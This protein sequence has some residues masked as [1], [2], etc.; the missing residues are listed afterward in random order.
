MSPAH[1]Q[2]Q[3]FAWFDLHGRR[4]L[5]WQQDINPYR[6]W[7]SEIMLQQ[8][9]VASVIGYFQR[10]MDRFPTV[11]HLAD[12]ELDDVL[13]HWAGLGYYA[14]A[15]NLHKTARLVAANGGEFPQT[16][17][18]LSALPGIG[19]ST[20]GAILSIAGG[21]SQPILDGN[22]KRVLTRFH[23]I[24]GWPGETRVAAQLWQLAETYTPKHRTADY[25]QAMMDLGATLCTRAKPLCEICPVQAGCEAKHRGLVRQLPAAKPRK[26]M[27]VKQCYMLLLTARDGAILLEKRPPT[28]IWGGLW[29]LPEFPDRPSAEIWCRE[30]GYC[31]AAVAALAQR[32]HTFSHYHLD[33]TPLLA[34]L[35]E[36][37]AIADPATF[38]WQAPEAWA[39][40]GLPTP[41]K[42]LLA[43]MPESD[44]AVISPGPRL[45]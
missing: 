15:R 9:Q 16:V 41:I 21:Q 18:A 38:A 2:Q 43:Q 23:A 44:G 28:G 11:R 26:S 32:R 42:Q 8:T 12:A 3:L 37:A 25:T 14:R 17:E 31:L 22:V 36:V 34:S 19:R 24:H 20:A 1:F 30:R 35:A 13:Q 40:L 33:Y 6:V 27:P 29:S 39:A 4:D 5:P 45:L 10:F 7:V